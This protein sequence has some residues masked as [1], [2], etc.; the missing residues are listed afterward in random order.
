M[1]DVTRH[2]TDLRELVQGRDRHG[3]PPGKYH[4]KHIELVPGEPV[5]APVNPQEIKQVVLNLITNALDSLSPG[6]RLTIELPVATA[7][8]P[9]SSSP[10]TAAA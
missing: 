8:R 7:I 1:G 5:V 4:D 10:T 6:G 9:S 2:E 3:R